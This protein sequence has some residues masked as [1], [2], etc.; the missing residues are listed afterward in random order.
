MILNKVTQ[1]ILIPQEKRD[2]A[3]SI[4]YKLVRHEKKKATVIQ[5]Q[6]LA[7]LLSPWKKFHK[8]HVLENV[9]PQS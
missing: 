1:T 5:I 9:G 6:Q 8:V 4:L 2:K 3:L 7:G